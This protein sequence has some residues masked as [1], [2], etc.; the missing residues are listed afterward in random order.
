MLKSKGLNQRISTMKVQCGEMEKSCK[1]ESLEKEGIYWDEKDDEDAKE[2][3]Y[4]L[5]GHNDKEPSKDLTSL[6]LG[7]NSKQ[8]SVIDEAKQ[9]NTNI[10]MQ[11]CEEMEAF[12]DHL[13]VLLFQQGV[14]ETKKALN[15]RVITWEVI[16]SRDGLKQCLL[17][18]KIASLYIG[19]GMD[20][21]AYS[22]V[23]EAE[24]IERRNETSDYHGTIEHAKFLRIMYAMKANYLKDKGKYEESREHLSQGWEI[25]QIHFENLFEDYLDFYVDIQGDLFYY[26]GDYEKAERSYLHSLGMRYELHHPRLIGLSFSRLVQLYSK[27]SQTGK[28]P[29]VG[30]KARMCFEKRDNYQKEFKEQ[31]QTMSKEK[32]LVGQIC[33]RM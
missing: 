21:Q 29:V 25:S 19:L 1:K 14:E 13:I 8:K 17:L 18:L 27:W 2:P 31:I 22:L 5:P 11:D 16:H 33:Y 20:E 24:D 4:H 30:E 23:E 7:Q 10:C 9:V 6:T 3:D 15:Q 32:V 12:I 26:S 28:N